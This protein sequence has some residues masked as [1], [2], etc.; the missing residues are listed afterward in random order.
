MIL[1]AF[2]FH[3][4]I[5][6]T[7]MRERLDKGLVALGFAILCA[8]AWFILLQ[9]FVIRAVCPFCMVAHACG[10]GVGML[11]LLT[12]RR[13]AGFRVGT[14]LGALAS[15]LLILGQ[16]LYQPAA[17]EVS[18]IP[19]SV[20]GR[21]SSSPDTSVTQTVEAA[22]AGDLEIKPVPRLL[23]LHKGGFTLD[24][25]EVPVIG[26]PAASNIVLHF[27]DYSC[28]HCRDLHPLLT[29]VHHA[30][31]ERLAIVNL[32]IPLEPD[33]NPIMKRRLAKHTN[34]CAYAKLG[35]AVWK[36]DPA[37]LPAFEDWVF[38]FPRPPAP[39]VVRQEAAKRVGDDAL[40]KAL[41]DPWIDEYL[42]FGIRLYHTNYLRFKK[43]R[44]PLLMTGTN[45]VSGMVRSTNDLYRILGVAP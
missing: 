7:L 18:T 35:L 40:R 37:Q 41:Q 42:A 44:L 36:A 39:D 21:P 6:T 15:T 12:K 27:F 14:I 33:C 38:S 4:R 45:L 10:L 34:A 32:P 31:E 13:A 28:D 3:R 1:A 26:S 2:L 5:P 22:P 43:S 20:V 30:L 11:L 24:L 29:N 8:A 17:F 9:L 23:H 16:V 19:D 25:N